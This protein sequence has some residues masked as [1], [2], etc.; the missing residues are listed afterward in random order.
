MSFLHNEDQAEE[1]YAAPDVEEVISS[2]DV[3]QEVL[4]AGG[5]PVGS[6]VVL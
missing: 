3:V 2:E 1:E 4:Y 6:G 5:A